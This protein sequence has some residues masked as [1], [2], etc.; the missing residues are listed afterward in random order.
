MQFTGAYAVPGVT[1]ATAAGAIDAF[2]AAITEQSDTPVWVLYNLGSND[3]A[4]ISDSSITEAAWKANTGYIFDAIHT[5]WPNAQIRAMRVYWAG[6]EAAAATLNDS[7]LPAVIS[8]RSGFV[9]VG[10]DERLF[11]PGNLTD[12]TH[13]NATGYSLTAAQWQTVMG[14]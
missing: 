12:A 9:A 13:P 5:K 11:L 10:P 8:T 3:L 1:T 7:W 14:Y 4:G 6:A 2:L